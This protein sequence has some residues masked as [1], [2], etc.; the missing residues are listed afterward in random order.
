MIE[1]VLELK[2]F[3]TPDF[4]TKLEI[5][6]LNVIVDSKR[7]QGFHRHDP[8]RDASSEILGQE[9]SQGHVLPLLDVTG[10]PVVHEDDAEDVLAGFVDGDGVTE[11]VQLASEEEG[12]LQLEV[13]QPIERQQGIQ[14][15]LI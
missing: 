7:H 14:V 10:R 1:Y 9:R 8:R 12:H 3:A 2:S 11:V 13:H 4:K 6:N 5:T 15:C